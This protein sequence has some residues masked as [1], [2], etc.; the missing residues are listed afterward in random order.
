MPIFGWRGNALRFFA[1]PVAAMQRMHAE[2]GPLVRLS[3]GAN[4]PLFFESTVPDV[5]THFVFGAEATRDLLHTPGRFEVRCPPGPKA[6]VYQRLATNI[7]FLNGERHA[8][9]KNLMRPWFTREHL[10]RYYADM[11]TA[12]GQMIED[13]R[14]R[15]TVNIDDEMRLATLVMSS[16]TLYGIEARRDE[17]HLAGMMAEMIHKLFSPAAMIPIDLPGTPLRRLLTLMRRID[18]ELWREIERKR[19]AGYAG[20]DILSGM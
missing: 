3:G 16:K 2:H 12:T 5:A 18:A 19:R 13:W 15:D 1:N 17:Q 11:V 7:L 9:Q 14:R 10:K 4:Q 20:S 6:D 8:Q